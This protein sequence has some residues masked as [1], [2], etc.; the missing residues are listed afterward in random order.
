LRLIIAEFIIADLPPKRKTKFRKMLLFRLL[1][2][3]ERKYVGKA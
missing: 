2:L 3:Y 1:V